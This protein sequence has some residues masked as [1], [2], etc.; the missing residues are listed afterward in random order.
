MLEVVRVE[1]GTLRHM[2]QT[3]R[4]IAADVSVGAYQHTEVTLI[5]THFPNG[6]RARVLPIVALLAFLRQWARQERYKMFLDADRASPWSTA[7]MRSAA[8]LMQIEMHHVKAHVS[9]PRDTK[10]R[11]GVRAIVVELPT[12]LVNQ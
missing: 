9:W 6:L 1:N 12:R 11:I 4:T 3:I 7:A 2:Q 8:R 5:R 10:H